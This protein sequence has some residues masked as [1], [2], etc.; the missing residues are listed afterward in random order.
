[1]LCARDYERLARQAIAAPAFEYIA[2]GSG[3]GRVAQANE[4][5]FADWAIQPRLLR[6]VRAGRLDVQLAGV[7]LEHPILLAPWAH[8]ALVHAGAEIETARGAHAAGA[9]LVGST[10]SNCTLEDI[11]RSTPGPKWFQLYFQPQRE[12]TGDLVAR[13]R[14]AGY[15]ALMVTLDAPVQVPGLDSQRAGFRLPPACVAANLAGYP[16][17]A[18][19]ALRAGQ[20]RIF[21]GFM[22]WAPRWPDLEWLL[23]TAHIPVWVKG[24]L[25]PEDAVALKD[26]GVAGIV[27][28]NHGGRALE[29]A[30]A[31][32]DAL[33][34][35]RAAVGTDYPVLFDGGIRSGADVFKAVALG[36][37]AILV[38][39]LQPY[40]LSVAGALGVAHMVKLLREELEVTMAL[41]GCGSMVQIR[42]ATLQRRPQRAAHTGA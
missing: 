41:A 36:A 20:S 15:Q 26:R 13:A 3:Q 21:D 40:A 2:G 33:P 11:A 1:M 22:Q 14:S 42:A 24:V 8:H 29:E 35:I 38:G 27:V 6:D 10:L 34:A 37:D 30:P 25:H 16:Q 12:V 5:A 4:A 19:V 32:L 17:P 7:R 18:P 31:S 9:C 28:S 23:E 39:R